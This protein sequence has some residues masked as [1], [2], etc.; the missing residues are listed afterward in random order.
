M[1]R[2]AAVKRTIAACANCGSGDLRR[3]DVPVTREIAGHV[4]RTRMPEFVCGACGERFSTSSDLA[5][6]DDAVA[7]TIADAGITAPAAIRYMRKALGMTGQ[8]L[9]DLLGVRKESIS[10]W[11]N[12]KREIDR[13]TFA[14]LRQL[15]V[16]QRAKETPVG[17]FLRRLHHPKRLGK[18]VT[19]KLAS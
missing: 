7:L 12:G 10:R 8:E 11:E 18:T 16:E 9:A 13:A 19:L 6:F 2:A 17:D 1:K 15:V 5:A 14:L 4:F 3:A